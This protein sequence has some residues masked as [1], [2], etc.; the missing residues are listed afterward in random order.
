MALAG[1]GPSGAR[2]GQVAARRDDLTARADD[3]GEGVFVG[4]HGQLV[5]HGVLAHEGRQLGGPDLAPIASR[6]SR[7]ERRSSTLRV[8]A[9]STS[10]TATTNVAAI[11][12][13]A[14]TVEQSLPQ[15]AA[16]ARDGLGVVAI[17]VT[18]RAGA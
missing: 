11:V 4:V 17:A 15:P 9:P 12:A 18:V 2:S 13:F 7:S 16:A 1:T 6:L 14:R 5:G 10:V 8:T 3:L